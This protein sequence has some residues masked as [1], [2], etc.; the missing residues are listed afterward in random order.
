MKPTVINP[1]TTSRAEAYEFW[2]NA[3]NPK[4]KKKCS[5]M[6]GRWC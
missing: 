3:P 1:K 2:M 5:T 6:F 4:E